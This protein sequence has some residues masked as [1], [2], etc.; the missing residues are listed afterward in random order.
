MSRSGGRCERKLQL[1]QS[2]GS[3]QEAVPVLP[4]NQRRGELAGTDTIAAL[5]KDGDANVVSPGSRGR[6][7]LYLGASLASAAAILLVSSLF[8]RSLAGQ[9]WP[10]PA[11]TPNT[12]VQCIGCLAPHS[13]LWRSSLG[14]ELNLSKWLMLLR[15]TR[16][17]APVLLWRQAFSEDRVS[18]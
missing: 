14:S 18:I 7:S 10:Y 15:L 6:R 17:P 9:Y 8:A 2:F 4:I 1:N 16:F 12:P 5:G 11:D 3:N 13:N